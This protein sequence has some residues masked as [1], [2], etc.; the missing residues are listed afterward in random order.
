M[1]KSALCVGLAATLA[2]A[3]SAAMAGGIPTPT[4]PLRVPEPGTFGMVAGAAIAMIFAARYIRR[5]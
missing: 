3:S 5:K 2:V 4:T 1:K